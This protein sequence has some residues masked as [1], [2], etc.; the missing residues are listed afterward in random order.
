MWRGEP[1]KIKEGG[2]KGRG[3]EKKFEIW[4]EAGVFT[5][6]LKPGY[7]IIHLMLRA[8]AT[9]YG[10]RA[11]FFSSPHCV[12][13]RRRKEK[14]VTT[15]YADNTNTAFRF[16]VLCLESTPGRVKITLIKRLIVSVGLANCHFQTPRLCP[17]Q[18]F[19]G[20]ARRFQARKQTKQLLPAAEECTTCR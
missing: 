2:E 3:G 8:A 12:I 14:C 15:S 11:V 6:F 18:T 4:V 20:A 5:G 1:T 16:K 19:D 17:P 13:M 9:Q 7:S 10:N